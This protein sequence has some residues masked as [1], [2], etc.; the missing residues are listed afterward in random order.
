MFTC[1]YDYFPLQINITVLF[2]GFDVA[3]LIPEVDEIACLNI[4]SD[5]YLRSQMPYEN[6]YD[7]TDEE[8]LKILLEKHKQRLKLQVLK[9]RGLKPF[10]GKK[11]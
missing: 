2:R 11:Y 3:L 4:R 1:Y 9:R 10:W 6:C 5:R 8:V 7:L